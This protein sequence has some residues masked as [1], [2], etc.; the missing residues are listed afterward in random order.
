MLV[1]TGKEKR[2]SFPDV[3][4]MPL[5]HGQGMN[6]PWTGT[7]S[8]LPLSIFNGVSQHRLIFQRLKLRHNTVCTRHIFLLSQWMF[9]FAFT[10]FFF[11]FSFI[12]VPHWPPWLCLS[13][14]DWLWAQS[15]A[16][17][18]SPCAIQCP[19]EFISLSMDRLDCL[20][21]PSHFAIPHNA[22]ESTC[23]LQSMH[24][25][26]ATL[27]QIPTRN[28]KWSERCS[29]AEQSADPNLTHHFI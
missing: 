27:P 28:A 24:Y 19:T 14:C 9:V 20:P 4:E 17:K 12:Q 25:P 10:F 21:I 16:V 11:S 26:V 15:A 8:Q 1:N 13:C 23:N 7:K 5:I 3:V 22:I 29:Y 2:F 6:Y 18:R